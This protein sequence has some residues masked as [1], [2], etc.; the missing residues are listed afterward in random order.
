MT[1]SDRLRIYC[2]KNGVTQKSLID[3]GFGT[4]QTI[5]NYWH[6]H[7]EPKAGFLEMFIKEFR[8]S[9]KWLMTG[10]E[11]NIK[12]KVVFNENHATNKVE[13]PCQHCEILKVKIEGLEA[14]LESK[15]ETIAALSRETKK[16]NPPAS[17]QKAG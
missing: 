15:N 9:A 14:L 10:E 16:E 11:E 13:E 12:S 1:V 2:E 6:G 8:L 17:N 3:K 4:S 5:N 7:T